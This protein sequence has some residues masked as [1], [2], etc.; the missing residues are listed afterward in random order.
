MRLSK[1]HQGVSQPPT[2]HFEVA[3]NVCFGAWVALGLVFF[4]LVATGHREIGLAVAVGSVL[5]LLPLSLWVDRRALAAATGWLREHAPSMPPDVLDAALA[6]LR[7]RFPLLNSQVEVL[8]RE[9][10][11]AR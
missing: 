9:L 2:T 11:L 10:T 1:S 6:D 4:V 7:R 5:I 3:A 8:T